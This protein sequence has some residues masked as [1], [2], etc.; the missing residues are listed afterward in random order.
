MTYD[1]RY[2]KIITDT[3]QRESIDFLKESELLFNF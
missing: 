1:F 3:E 2:A